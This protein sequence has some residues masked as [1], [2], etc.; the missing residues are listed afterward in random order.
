MIK[1]TGFL[2]LFAFTA[3]FWA[4]CEEP[5]AN[6]KCMEVLATA[7]NST[8]AQ[9][10]PGTAGNITAWGDTLKEGMLSVAISRD[11]LDSGFVHGSLITI[12]GYDGKTFVVNDKMN[13]RYTNRIDLYMGES[14]KKARKFGKQKLRICLQLPDEK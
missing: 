5:P 6:E 1:S 13:A 9:T 10:R 12:E 4:S 2:I 8:P 3:L 11:L 14:I 7:Y